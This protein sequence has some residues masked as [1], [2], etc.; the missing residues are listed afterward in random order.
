MHRPGAVYDRSKLS[1]PL[2]RYNISSPSSS[3][4][5]P[6]ARSPSSLDQ[7]LINPSVVR[8]LRNIKQNSDNIQHIELGISDKLF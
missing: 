6:L 8:S 1:I 2:Q 5:S 7:S 3:S 4:S